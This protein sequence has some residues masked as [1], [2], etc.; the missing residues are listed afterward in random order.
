MF[1]I[2]ALV[3]I[4]AALALDLFTLSSGGG[5]RHCD[6]EQWPSRSHVWPF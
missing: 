5:S 2:I 6:T 3:I 4:V 1:E